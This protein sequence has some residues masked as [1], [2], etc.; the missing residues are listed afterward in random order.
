MHGYAYEPRNSVLYPGISRKYSSIIYGMEI[1]TWRLS[2]LKADQLSFEGIMKMPTFCA[3]GGATNLSGTYSTY[4]PLLK[5]GK[6]HLAFLRNTNTNKPCQSLLSRLWCI[7]LNTDKLTIQLNSRK[8][9]LLQGQQSQLL[10]FCAH[11]LSS[12]VSSEAL[13]VQMAGRIQSCSRACASNSIV[14]QGR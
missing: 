6:P 8:F 1:S 10:I 3:T 13:S 9:K 4:V 14:Q 11:G 2:N 7:E 5:M 12:N